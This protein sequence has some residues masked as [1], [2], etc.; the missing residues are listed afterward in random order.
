MQDGY[1]MAV[2][3]LLEI[4]DKTKIQLFAVFAA[5]PIFVGFVFWISMIYFKVEAAEKV[6]ERQEVKLD[7]QMNV[8]LDIRDK[9]TRVEERLDKTNKYTER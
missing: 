6:N 5:I 2:G 8:L 3:E 1:A 7:S 4:N 9:V